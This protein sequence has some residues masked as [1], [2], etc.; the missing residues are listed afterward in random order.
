MSTIPG[1]FSA[2]SGPLADRVGHMLSGVSA[3]VAVKIY[4]PDL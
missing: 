4:G 2:M 3:K 1:T